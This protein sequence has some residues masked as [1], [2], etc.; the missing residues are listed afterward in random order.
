LLTMRLAAMMGLV[1]ALVGTPAGAAGLGKPDRAAM[2]RAQRL[3]QEA[4]SEVHR[5][6][7][8]LS[9][10]TAPTRL[11]GTYRVKLHADYPPASEMEWTVDV[12]RTRG[13]AAVRVFDHRGVR[14]AKIPPRTLDAWARTA[15]HLARVQV[16]ETC[17][18][19]PGFG[20]ASHVSSRTLAIEAADDEVLMQTPHVQPYLDLLHEEHDEMEQ[21]ASTWAIRE[22][23]ALA[24]RAV[25]KVAP[26]PVPLDEAR[27]ALRS[28]S[29]GDP[30]SGSPGQ[31][32]AGQD[33]EVVETRLF[34]HHLAQHGEE[35]DVD[36]LLR[37]GFERLAFSLSLRRV[38]DED[39]PD[40]ASAMLCA[41]DSMIVD[42]GLG[43]VER[44]G[45]RA[46]GPLLAGLVCEPA[47]EYYSHV[48]S[49]VQQLARLGGRDPATLEALRKIGGPEA[50]PKLRVAVA[51]ALW[52]LDHDTSQLDVL[53]EIGAENVNREMSDAQR[54][55]LLHLSAFAAREPA[56]KSKYAPYFAKILQAI[57]LTA[58]P[59]YG[60]VD[61]M[62]LIVSD[63]GGRT[64][65]AEYRRFLAHDSSDAVLAAIRA[66]ATY[67][68]QAAAR[69]AH[70]R[71]RK[72]NAG[73]VDGA[74][75]SWNVL[76]YLDLFIE[77]DAT[78]VLP[79]LEAALLLLT[80]SYER[81]AWKLGSHEATLAYLRARTKKHKA[82]AALA[83]IRA[84]GPQRASFYA[85]CTTQLGLT[86]AELE[87]AERQH[88]GLVA[89]DDAFD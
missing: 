67:D 25:K 49:L 35:R 58:H 14:H 11:P 10:T 84:N 57:P 47:T 69:E 80:T 26:E 45:E 60:G 1:A 48:P 62:L 31:D 53:A 51:V 50:K 75:Y 76:P 21:F 82:A 4:R 41:S 6:C 64:Y 34:A 2:A 13:H 72:H 85:H 32:R 88:E 3:V 27:A 12:E 43:V 33:R 20:F 55:A 18:E 78:Y 28:F 30:S 63:F 73:E 23:E 61:L 74:I 40:L 86:Q 24:F 9:W 15:I 89:A 19:H 83:F 17:V 22:L 56:L 7:V 65:D 39:L 46:R 77:T 42:A 70:V 37:G 71:V 68:E 8:E 38:P 29:G 44:L 54:E 52:T 81:D 16:T 5:R 59:S 66:I 87:R 79:D 36:L